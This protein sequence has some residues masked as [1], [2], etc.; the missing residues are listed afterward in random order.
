VT[1]FKLIIK[2]GNQFDFWPPVELQFIKHWIN[3]Q[4]NLTHLDTI[5]DMEAVIIVSFPKPVLQLTL[6][7]LLAQA[8]ILYWCNLKCH[9]PMYS[10]FW[11]ALVS[12]LELSAARGLAARREGAGR[13][14]SSL[15]LIVDYPSSLS[16]TQ[17]P[18]KR[19]RSCTL[20]SNSITQFGHNKVSISSTSKIRT[21]SVTTPDPTS[22]ALFGIFQGT[23]NAWR[24]FFAGGG[25]F[26]GKERRRR[27]NPSLSFSYQ[28]WLSPC[29]FD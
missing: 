25:S 4:I 12:I 17:A 11:F 19:T 22:I 3:T 16:R 28:N 18:D 20:L 2:S 7:C 29:R 26:R 8:N 14:R 24:L 13:N 21:T 15:W 5:Y 1:R 23:R 6:P 27:Q 9:V 10:I